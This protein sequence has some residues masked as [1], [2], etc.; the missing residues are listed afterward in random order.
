MNLDFSQLCA[1][2]P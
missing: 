2:K 1:L